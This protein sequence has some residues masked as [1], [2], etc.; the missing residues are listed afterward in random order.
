MVS[1][2]GRGYRNQIGVFLRW[3]DQIMYV[4]ALLAGLVAFVVAGPATAAQ[5]KPA[6]K[7]KAPAA[8]TVTLDVTGMH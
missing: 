4:R 2:P 5:P 7:A 6:T 8:R 3:E 1:A